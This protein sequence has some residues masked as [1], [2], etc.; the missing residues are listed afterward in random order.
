MEKSLQCRVLR[1]AVGVGKDEGQC[2]GSSHA[3]PDDSR[4]LGSPEPS[5]E[6]LRVSGRL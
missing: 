3:T 6:D 5:L 4:R 1:A 2:G